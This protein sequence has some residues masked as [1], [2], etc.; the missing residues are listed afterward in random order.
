MCGNL[1]PISVTKA[2]IGMLSQRTSREIAEDTV[3][4]EKWCG[5]RPVKRDEP[6]KPWAPVVTKAPKIS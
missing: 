2:E 3:A 5:A 6:I 4:K 1:F